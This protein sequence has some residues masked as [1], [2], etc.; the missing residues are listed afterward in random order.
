[1]PHCTGGRSSLLCTG[2][3]NDAIMK[4][5][6]KNHEYGSRIREVKRGAFTAL[7]L[8]TTGGMGVHCV[9]KRL[10]EH[11]VYKHKISYSLV[12]T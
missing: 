1:M 11:L 7:V 10:A 4:Q 2:Y 9:Y 12:M 3:N 8:S 5:N 6:A